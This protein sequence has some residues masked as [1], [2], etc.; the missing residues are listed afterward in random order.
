MEHHHDTEQ[1]LA[2]TRCDGWTPALK[3]RFLVLLAEAGNVRLS[4]RRCGRSA[5]SVYVQ[6]RR[7]PVFARA[8]M[9]ALVHAHKHGEQVLADR[10]L[11]GV[12][13]P[14]FYRGEL[15]GTRRRYDSRLLLAHLARLDKCLEDEAALRDAERFDELVALVAGAE[16]PETLARG[17]GVLPA[18][19]EA[20][21][22]GA[23][24]DAEESADRDLPSDC[25]ATSEPERERALAAAGD[26]AYAAAAT[27]WDTWFD[28]VC[29]VVDGLEVGTPSQS[30]DARHPRAGG[31]PS[32]EVA[33]ESESGEQTCEGVD[34]AEE[35][36]LQDPVNAS[37]SPDLDEEYLTFNGW[38]FKRLADRKPREIDA[39]GHPSETVGAAP[40]QSGPA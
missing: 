19:R 33:T 34:G 16:L 27:E 28:H 7:D 29:A 17:R 32:A 24:V 23:A 26:A 5:Q 31:D 9:G 30:R 21:A 1:F 4:A 15:V 39:A 2:A 18:D 37:T 36:S 12:E 3:A 8:W 20:Y 11:E 14:I 40:E 13:E 6:R 25:G 38:T 10:A 22:E 35:L